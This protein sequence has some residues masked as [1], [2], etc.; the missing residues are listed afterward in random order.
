MD[1]SSI[2][3]IDKLYIDGEFVSPVLNQTFEVINPSD[4][5]VLGLAPKGSS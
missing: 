2:K 4:E 3:L 5:T 1:I